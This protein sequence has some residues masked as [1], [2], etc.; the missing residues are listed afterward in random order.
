MPSPVA[1]PQPPAQ[2]APP[3]VT[4]EPLHKRAIVMDGFKRSDGLFEVEARLQDTKPQA[5]RPPSGTKVVAAGES[6]HEMIVRIVF[7]D[8]LTVRDVIVAAPALPYAGCAGGPPAMKSLIGLKMSAGWSTAVRQKL[9]GAAGCT[10]LMGLM[11]PMAATAYQSLTVH[12]LEPYLREGKRMPPRPDSCIAYSRHGELI[13]TLWPA[14]YQP[15]P[16]PPELK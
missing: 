4:R 6:I 7:D 11:V 13:R 16:E 14:S 9:A 2:P 5:F 3:E 8:D 1:S 10:H 15:P 12:R